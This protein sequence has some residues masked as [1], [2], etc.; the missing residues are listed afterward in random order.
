[1]KPSSRKLWCSPH[2][3]QVGIPN[4]WT[5]SL[6]SQQPSQ[7]SPALS[8][9]PAL[10]ETLVHYTLKPPIAP[11]PVAGLGGMVCLT[12]SPLFP[13]K[14]FKGLSWIQAQL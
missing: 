8:S 12:I 3:S 13:Q 4:S 9:L 11:P 14:S 6:P 1:M 2:R 7:D 5:H 10:P